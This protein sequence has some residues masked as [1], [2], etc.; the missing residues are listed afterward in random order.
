MIFT[1]G[2]G[3]LLVSIMSSL[4]RSNPS[5]GAA[6]E[7]ANKTKAHTNSYMRSILVHEEWMLLVGGHTFTRPAHIDPVFA[8]LAASLFRILFAWPWGITQHCPFCFL[9]QREGAEIR[10]RTDPTSSRCA[11]MHEPSAART[12]KFHCSSGVHCRPR[13]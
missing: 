11:R 9:L 12:Y 5:T 2:Y 13:H 8:C 1:M 6:R 3:A 4:G 10:Q 7:G